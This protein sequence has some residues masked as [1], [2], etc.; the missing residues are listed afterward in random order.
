MMLGFSCLIL[1]LFGLQLAVG[2]E[3]NKNETDNLLSRLPLLEV[4]KISRVASKYVSGANIPEVVVK[5][6]RKT[7]ISM[8]NN[9][10]SAMFRRKLWQEVVKATSEPVIGYNI[11]ISERYTASPPPVQAFM[12]S[13]LPVEINSQCLNAFNY[14][15]AYP[16]LLTCTPTP[17]KEMLEIIVRYSCM[18]SVSAIFKKW[19]GSIFILREIVQ[20]AI[21]LARSKKV[22]LVALNSLMSE[23]KRNPFKDLVPIGNNIGKSVNW[24]EEGRH[25]WQFVVARSRLLY[26]I[27]SPTRAPRRGEWA[28]VLISG[29]KTPRE[30]LY[31]RD[32]RFLR[33]DS[34]QLTAAVL[35]TMII[36][37]VKNPSKFKSYEVIIED[38]NKKLKKTVNSNLLLAFSARLATDYAYISNDWNDQ[39]DTLLEIDLEER[40]GNRNQ[41]FIWHSRPFVSLLFEPDITIPHQLVSNCVRYCEDLVSRGVVTVVGASREAESSS[42]LQKKLEAICKKL[43]EKILPYTEVYVEPPKDTP[44]SILKSPTKPSGPS[45]KRLRFNDSVQVSIYEKGGLIT[46]RTP[47][48]S[49]PLDVSLKTSL[50]NEGRSTARPEI[51]SGAQEHQDPLYG[52]YKLNMLDY[53]DSSSSQNEGLF[54]KT[55]YPHEEERQCS[56]LTRG[57]EHPREVNSTSRE[58]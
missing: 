35:F 57:C 20:K 7:R 36:F 11:T 38:H 47:A 58:E 32:I 27:D 30:F 16:N 54:E 33:T 23:Y 31:M 4:S 40:Q 51:P 15:S 1:F 26:S 48:S 53:I 41:T 18:K 56:N 6:A 10:K 12:K 50:S 49:F 46:E 22:P 21:Y 44:K 55:P 45:K 37:K 13:E 14:L 39:I 24:D 42:F 2:V 8:Q 5:S 29:S 19:T 28:F 9:Y 17:S 3:S 34:V 43:Q 25:I 52:D